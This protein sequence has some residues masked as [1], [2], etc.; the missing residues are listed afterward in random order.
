MAVTYKF[1]HKDPGT[2]TTLTTAN[3]LINYLKGLAKVNYSGVKR[4]TLIH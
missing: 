1:D 2:S 4:A 3:T